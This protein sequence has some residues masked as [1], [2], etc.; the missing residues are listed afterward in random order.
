MQL[1]IFARTFVRPSLDDTLDAVKSYG[2]DCLQFNF[3]CIGQPTLPE[4]IDP[5]L[6]FRIRTELE[7]RSLAMVAVSGTCNLIHPDPAQ[8]AQCLRRLQTMI[9]A[10]REFGTSVVT[11]CSGTR[12]AT[13]MW[14][15]HRENHS[16]SARRD[17]R[18][19]LETLLPLAEKHDVTLG[20]EPELANVI[21]TAQ[22]ARQLLDEL[23][24]P[25]LKIVFDAA[26][27]LTS[28]ALSEQGSVLSEAAHLL[29]A[30]TVLAHGKDLSFEVPKL[31][32]A[33]GTGG[34]DYSLYLS[35]LER[36]GFNGAIVLHSLAE[37]E[38][39]ASVAFLRSQLNRR[40]TRN[41]GQSNALLQ[42]RPN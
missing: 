42:P 21:A 12:D 30:D 40:A 22:Q 4:S 36:A 31:T 9:P 28:H 39:P 11:L 33:A 18:T 37:T 7:K 16:L 8:R 17:L 34:L 3:S 15:S 29:G 14:R 13:D 24:S 10:C 20:I 35:L 5:A 23:K 6:A 27:L 26:N 38:V 1:G 25:C 32:V 41:T 19:S 2:L